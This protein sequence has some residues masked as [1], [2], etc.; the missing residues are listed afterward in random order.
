MRSESGGSVNHSAPLDTLRARQLD[1]DALA[2]LET[3]LDDQPALENLLL[4]TRDSR[5]PI[6][7][8][9]QTLTAELLELKAWSYRKL[10]AC[11]AAGTKSSDDGLVLSLLPGY[12]F[13]LHIIRRALPF[14]FLRLPVMCAFSRENVITGGRVVAKIAK[15]LGMNRSLCPARSDAKNLLKQ[16]PPPQVALAIVTGRRDTVVEVRRTL[17]A[18]R[19]VGCT[20][21]C[22]IEIRARF[23]SDWAVSSNTSRSCTTIRASF[24]KEGA[25]WRGKETT[26]D[27]SVV[28]R[29]LHPSIILDKTGT[30]DST[31]EG[32][33]CIQPNRPLN[34][35][36]FAA[37][38]L[39]G[40]PGD[41]LLAL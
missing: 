13:A 7:I 8:W 21:R 17:G 25:R 11:N 37:D 36:G 26:W 14:A 29:R 24:I 34:L 6:S 23:D 12:G 35:R 28:V 3:L 40:W 39:F 4:A 18:E 30:L 31:I 41:Y 27:P 2:A 10:M 19:V 1:L 16:T 38:P 15:A 22:A 5:M 9:R 32:Y 20:G 33:C